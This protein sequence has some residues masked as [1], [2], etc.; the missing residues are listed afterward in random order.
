MVSFNEK[1]LNSENLTLFQTDM[2]FNY[3]IRNHVYE[4]KYN[5]QKLTICVQLAEWQLYTKNLNTQYMLNNNNSNNTRNEN[6]TTRAAEAPKMLTE[7]ALAIMP[8][9]TEC[10]MFVKFNSYREKRK[11]KNRI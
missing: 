2:L 1:Y 10:D 6:K 7:K 11:F 3:V 4:Y 8:T 9:K 5:G